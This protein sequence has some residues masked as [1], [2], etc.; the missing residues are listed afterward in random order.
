VALG[1]IGKKIGMTQIFSKDGEMMSVTVIEAGPCAVVQK[2]TVAKDGYCAIKIGFSEINPEKLTKPLKGQ[3]K[4]LNGKAYSFLQELRVENADKYEVGDNLTLD[5][6]D[7]G[8]TVNV[9]GVSKGKGFQGGIKRWGFSRG[10]MTHG[11]KFHRARGSI[12]SSA[13]P[14]RVFKGRKMP[15]HMGAKKVTVKELKIIDKKDQENILFIR[16]SI[17]GANNGLITIYKK[18]I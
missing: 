8:E 7:L 1:L 6:F 13:D 10:P 17:P 9:S 3:F 14:S 2:K 16:G 4:K 12:G 5:M 18:K 11:S 15:G